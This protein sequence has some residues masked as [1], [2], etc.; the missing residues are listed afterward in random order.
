LN[1]LVGLQAMPSSIG[2]PDW[3]CLQIAWH[4]GRLSIEHAETTHAC[5]SDT[6][7]RA[8]LSGGV[9]AVNM[10]LNWLSRWQATAAA[11]AGSRRRR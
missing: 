8:F 6:C 11:A 9:H 2:C 7:S 5:F 1:L 10:Q 3:P 4:G